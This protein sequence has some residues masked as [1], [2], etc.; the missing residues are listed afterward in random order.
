[1]SPPIKYLLFQIPGWLVAAI[2]LLLAVHWHWFTAPLAV[3]AFAVWVLK[4]LLFYPL[5]HRAYEPGRTGAARLVGERGVVE[6]DLTPGG[7]VRVRGELWRAA[8]FPENQAIASGTEVE[9][10]GAERMELTVRAAKKSNIQRR[11]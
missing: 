7:Y 11:S 6:G 2:I 4:D 5:L 3:A 8:A 1:V 10:I 9:I